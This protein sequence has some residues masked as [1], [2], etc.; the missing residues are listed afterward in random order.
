MP[1]LS[2]ADK[3]RV[4]RESF[5]FQTLPA[6]DLDRLAERLQPRRFANGQAIFGRGDP[7]SSMMAVIEGK[8][9]IGL[10]AS[11]GREML[12]GIV[13]PGEV[14][15]EL[16]LLDGKM[17]SADATAV[18]SCVLLSLDRRDLLPVLR[19]SPDLVI[20]LAEVLCARLRAANDRLE[21]TAFMSVGAR[22]AR[23]LL[24]LA[25]TESGV[26]ATIDAGLSQSDLGRL[27]NA[28]RQK[29]NRHLCRWIRAGVLL[30]SGPNLVICKPAYLRNIAGAED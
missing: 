19:Q 15:G 13:E 3:H 16:A 26:P 4:L 20:S 23:L 10:T 27:I 14:F 18:G 29:V 6:A 9:R 1:S 5:L 28:S 11:D 12:L 21:G 25:R 24:R 30:R 2:H 22:L 8:V 7:G 17:R